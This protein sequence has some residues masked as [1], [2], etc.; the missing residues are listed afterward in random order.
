MSPKKAATAGEDHQ[1]ES[2][3][4]PASE[5]GL[6]CQKCCQSTTLKDS[7]AN[8]RNALKRNCL[9]CVATDK[10]LNR[11]CRKPKED[12]PE[13]E[14]QKDRRE[15]A[16]AQRSQLSKMSNEEKS[17]WYVKQKEERKLQE[18][19]TKRTFC[20]GVGFVQETQRTQFSQNE[21]DQ[22]QTSDMWCEKMMNLKK[23]DSL[24]AAE[25]AFRIECKKPG[26]KT[27]V[28]RGQTLL[29]VFQGIE[30]SAGEEHSLEHGVRQRADLTEEADLAEFKEEASSRA[31]KAKWRLD[32][33]RQACLEGTLEGPT[34]LLN[35]GQDI[36]NAKAMEAELEAQ[37][38]ENLEAQ[39]KEKKQAPKAE[40]IK[41]IAV[42]TMGAETA[43]ERSFQAMNDAVSRQ[44]AL[45]LA[46]AE[47]SAA[48][49]TE[50]MRNEANERQATCDELLPRVCQEI[51]EQKAKWEEQ[52]QRGSNSKDAQAIHTVAVEVAKS[53]KEWLQAQNQ[54]SDDE[55]ELSLM[56]RYKS[57]VKDWKAFLGKCKAQSKKK[58]KA[59][60]KANSSA[61]SSAK[62]C[63]GSSWHNLS[64][65]KQAAD[66]F[67][68]N[69]SLLV[70]KGM[71]WHLEKDLLQSPP[72]WEVA[73]VTWSE[74]QAGPF[75]T[76]MSDHEYYKFQ[77]V[78]VAEQ[79]KK[80][81][82]AGFLSA[83]ITKTVIAKKVGG[84]WSKLC[85]QEALSWLTTD[86]ASVKELFTPQFFQQADQS[87]QVSLHADFGMPDA[88]LLFEG[89]MC[90]VG[91][92]K[93]KVPGQTLSEKRAWLQ[94]ATWDA[95]SAQASWSVVL[96]SGMGVVI[97]GDHCFLAMALS[98]CHGGRIHVLLEQHAL[99]TKAI[100]EEEV[101]DN[102]ALGSLRTGKLLAALESKLAELSE[103]GPRRRTSAATA[104]PSAASIAAVPAE[105]AGG[106]AGA[107]EG[108][109]EKRAAKR[110]RTDSA[111][112]TAAAPVVVKPR[113][114]DLGQGVKP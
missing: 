113:A 23:Y 106:G 52:L 68:N 62:L 114:K 36:Q 78:W 61:M 33:D 58:D 24:E 39:Q 109:G 77:K 94:N 18:R 19:G 80:T 96:K 59:A 17:Q 28:C 105:N 98:E 89:T 76:S 25:A 66:A 103:A 102:A 35:V 10:C 55:S 8:G 82:A 29:A 46:A 4:V 49:E 3:E 51:E 86:D 87:C 41:S 34:S 79:M 6:V 110:Q 108:A 81:G 74:G 12:K 5:K 71:K 92:P 91:F 16:E 67:K 57:A 72:G 26:A 63:S 38:M 48:L 32:A 65:C 15:K 95:F 88:R 9:D 107:A 85:S 69:S 75:C 83:A 13:S 31:T 22:F 42:E 54:R 27:K 7:C 73:P 70:D 20:T 44:K 60:T 100:C 40:V 56:A 53:L 45:A 84:L 99:R 112:A 104:A 111:G 93:S 97:P 43:I 90:L 2:P 14:S 37:W 11:A 30:I 1:G 21:L 50:Q 101:A 64:L 47:E